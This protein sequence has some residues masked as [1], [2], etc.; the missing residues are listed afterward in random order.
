MRIG[1]LQKLTLLDYPGKVACTV[2]SAGC[3]LRCPFCH[4]A[5]LVLGE[6][7]ACGLSEAEFFAFL[8]KR[9]RVLDGV[10]VSGGEPLL[11]PD[12]PDFLRRVKAL[13]LLVKLDTNG[14]FPGR[15]KELAAQGLVDTV[16]MDVKTAPAHY[17]E[18]VGIPGFDASPVSESIRF[19]LGG[20]LD[21]EFR[22]TAVRGLH[23]AAILREAAQSVAGAKRYFLQQFVDSGD[24]VA[25][26]NAG[27]SA[28]TPAE[29]RAFLGVVSPYV[30]HVALRGTA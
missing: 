14:T 16:A 1:G 21:Y 15:L 12:L 18:A 2:F 11:Q 17:G 7:G 13:G 9:A 3:N 29:M 23:T 6:P 20:T 25:G 28:F 19:L 8:Q 4:N 5:P 22:T 24:L 30:R 10:C 27:Y 26:E